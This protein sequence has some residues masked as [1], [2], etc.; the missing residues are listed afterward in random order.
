MVYSHWYR[1]LGKSQR[2]PG[3]PA[4][5]KVRDATDWLRVFSAKMVEELGCKSILKVKPTG[6]LDVSGVGRDT[7]GGQ[8]WF[9]LAWIIRRIELPSQDEEDW[10]KEALEDGQFI[11]C[12]CVCLCF[13]FYFI[14]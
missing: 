10:V 11:V 12:V 9:W 14:L 4:T 13:D 8:Y 7:E 5:I 6:F 3:A 2:T 1:G